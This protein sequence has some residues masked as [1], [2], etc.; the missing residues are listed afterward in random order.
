MR[1]SVCV[2]SVFRGMDTVE[3]MRRVRL[4]G[5]GAYEFWSWWDKDIG[6]VKAAQEENG[7]TLTAMC[8]KFVSLVDPAERDRY[9]EGLRESLEAARALGCKLLISQTGQ[10]RVGVPR[11]EQ[12]ASLADGLRACVPLLEEAG[13]TLAVEPLN[14]AVDHA[15]YFLSSSDEAFGIVREVGSPFVKVLFD[16]YHQQ[17]TEGDL[18]RRIRANRHLIGHFH[19]A[20]HPGRGELDAGEIH[21]EN[22]LGA[23]RETG[24]EGYVGL[25]YFTDGDPMPGLL[26]WSDKGKQEA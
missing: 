13:V 6:A 14:T 25:E 21:Y 3:A 15:G 9:L 17:I 5:Y 19:A 10:D 4:A 16:V 22:V 12:R 26:R 18:I 23:I 20:G 11:D 2:D 24:Y 1:M 7:L 8:T